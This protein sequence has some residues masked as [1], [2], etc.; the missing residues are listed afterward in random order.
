MKRGGYL[1]TK[2]KAI[3]T[4]EFEGFRSKGNKK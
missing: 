3:N 2:T 1:K 4:R